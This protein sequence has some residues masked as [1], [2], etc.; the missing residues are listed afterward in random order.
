[1]SSVTLHW[2]ISAF[3]ACIVRVTTRYRLAA[4]RTRADLKNVAPCHVR[5]GAATFARHVCAHISVEIKQELSAAKRN[6]T[7]QS[8]KKGNIGLL[9]YLR[10]LADVHGLTDVG[11][12][13][14]IRRIIDVAWRDGEISAAPTVTAGTAATSAAEAS[15]GT[16]T[17]N[18]HGI[19]NDTQGRSPSN[20]LE[21]EPHTEHHQPVA[22][23]ET[24]S[25]HQHPPDD[26]SRHFFCSFLE[27][28]VEE[29]EV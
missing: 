26:Y 17:M 7:S 25:N 3:D 11:K 5:H 2:A 29:V 1:M 19:Q 20:P 27:D 28:V 10:L 9:A 15:E 23:G 6:S 13:L 18:N 4:F 21:N 24:R 22:R 14:G 8:M 16:S 12:K